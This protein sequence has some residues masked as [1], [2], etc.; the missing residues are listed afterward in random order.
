MTTAP[1][2]ITIYIK[3]GKGPISEMKLDLL[4][5]ET[6]VIKTPGVKS[7]EARLDMIAQQ[8]QA[9]FPDVEPQKGMKSLRFLIGRLSQVA[10]FDGVVLQLP[11]SIPGDAPAVQAAPDVDLL[12]KQKNKIQELT[13][14]LEE[15][16]KKL[17]S[18]QQMDPQLQSDLIWYRTKFSELNENVEQLRKTVEEKERDLQSLTDRQAKTF[19]KAKEFKERLEKLEQER[20]KI[21]TEIEQAKR[22]RTNMSQLRQRVASAEK[23]EQQVREAFDK[24]Q[25]ELNDYRNRVRQLTDQIKRGAGGQ[26]DPYAP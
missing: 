25:Q 10:L 16:E 24:S 12:E 6:A 3:P 9:T 5:I 21:Q 19:M 4:S 14:R 22:D 8:I 18:A 17:A 2:V 13:S 15:A 23:A 26:S 7:D 20:A 1:Y 11:G